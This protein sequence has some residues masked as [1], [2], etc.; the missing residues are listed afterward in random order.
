M[1]SLLIY[2]LTGA[3]AGLLAGLFGVGGGMIMVPALALVLPGQGVPPDVVMQVAVATSL[4]VISATSVSSMLSH[5]KHGAVLWPV[6]RWMALGLVLGSVAGA[7]VAD[8]LASRTLALFV[9]CGALAV[10]VQMA[11]DLKP[12][13]AAPLPGPGVLI[14]AGGVIGLLSA[15]VGIGGGSLTVPFLGWRSVDIRKAVGTSAAC[16]VPIAWAGALGFIASGWDRT[17]LPAPH[18]GYV[19]LHGFAGL[20]VASVLMAPLGAR[21]AHRL[22]P[23]QLKRGFA[24]LLAGVG[25]KMLIG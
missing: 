10:A 3:I 21:L 4:A 16:G 19:S 22:P 1:E 24:L 25:L 6:F 9:G 11:L 2:V 5:Q 23:Q 8:R 14:G 7:F 17:D 15:L 20:A 18:L 13:A 12:K